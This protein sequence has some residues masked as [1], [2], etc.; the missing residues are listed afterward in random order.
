MAYGGTTFDILARLRRE[1]VLSG[2]RTVM[3]VG[4]QEASV[5]SCPHYAATF[6]TEFGAGDVPAA[7]LESLLAPRFVRPLWNRV[8]IDYHATDIDG[9][10]GTLFLDLNFDDVPLEY[11][12]RFDLTTNC[13]T[14]EHVFNQMNAFRAIHDLTKPG[15]YMYHDLPWSGMFSHGFVNY[16][17]SLFRKLCESNYYNWTGMWLRA[18]VGDRT[19]M[20]DE[21]LRYCT[22]KD[23]EFYKTYFGHDGA[24]AVVLQKT[25]DA[26]FVCP[27]EIEGVAVFSD[28][29]SCQRY[30]TVTDPEGRSKVERYRREGFPNEQTDD[31]QVKCRQLEDTIAR[32]KASAFWKARSVLARCKR[33]MMSVLDPSRRRAA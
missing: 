6:L 17:P 9:Q 18:E 13:G 29:K 19:A 1:G 15:G 26:P 32:M 3:D 12:N 23:A 27:L 21:V 11:R 33:A 24:I 16:K 31:P 7:E 28:A 5:S 20:P 4:T 10:P 22:D 14:T 2:V 30:W 25:S 8:G